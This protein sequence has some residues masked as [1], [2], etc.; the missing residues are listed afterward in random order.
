MFRC[1]Q[2]EKDY[3]NYLKGKRVVIVGPAPYMNR[4][5]LGNLIDS[6]DVVVRLNVALPLHPLAYHCFGRKTN[7]LY[8]SMSEESGRDFS[9]LVEGWGLDYLCSSY[10]NKRW[11]TV[12]NI[13]F[14]SKGENIAFRIMPT[15]GWKKLLWHLD[16][17]P[18]TGT[19]AIVDLLR[20][21]IAELFIAGF[22][23]EMGVY[24]GL[25]RGEPRIDIIKVEQK[26]S[27]QPFIELLHDQAKQRELLVSICR[28]DTRV[29]VDNCLSNL[30]EL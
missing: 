6:Y 26:D 27:E 4:L 23:F 10:P 18:N 21:N 15:R 25:S 30:L 11:Y 19:M 9:S 24:S 2:I 12:A 13:R 17:T 29:R 28:N 8:H 20:Y 3:A 22:S 7:I 14:L 16:S 5:F 1:R